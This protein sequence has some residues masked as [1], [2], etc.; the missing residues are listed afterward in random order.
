[1][2]LTLRVH[3]RLTLHQNVKYLSCKNN[4]QP[5]M[6]CILWRLESPHSAQDEPVLI[7]FD[8]F[9]PECGPPTAI[10]YSHYG[11]KLIVSLPSLK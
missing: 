1:M 4:W 7:F 8:I 11:L 3:F 10:I 6:H 9:A 5:Y 2:V